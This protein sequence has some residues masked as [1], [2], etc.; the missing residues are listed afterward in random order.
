MFDFL[1]KKDDNAP[2]VGKE[3]DFEKERKKFAKKS[4]EEQEEA[5]VSGDEEEEE[6]EEEEV[7][8]KSTGK[9][10]G[11]KTS[12]SKSSNVSYENNYALEKIEARLEAL[13]E[14]IKGYNERFSQLSQQIGETRAMA[15]S[16]EKTIVK[17][18]AEA[19]KTI[20]VVKEVEPEKLRLDYQRLN[21]KISEVD[22]K[23]ETKKQFEE[24]LMNE[25]KDLRRKAGIFIGTEALLKLNE[26]VKK[27]LMELQRLSS[28][29]NMQ[30][31]KSEQIFIELQRGFAE[32]QKLT[33][34]AR[35]LDVN[36]AGL[37]K[38][39]EKLKL[40]Y[41]TIVRE[42]EIE[43]MKKKIDD[44]MSM[45]ESYLGQMEEVKKDNVR[46]SQMI[47]TAIEV[48]R[49]NKEDVEDIAMSLGND[50]I[51][52]VSDYENQLASVLKIIDTLAG[53]LNE[54]RAKVGISGEKKINV[55]KHDNKM[56]GKEKIN[57][58]NFELH[59]MISK[60]LVQK[61]PEV[62]V[63]IKKIQDRKDSD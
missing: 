8:E 10:S 31:D 29:V 39:I 2:D 53:R 28:R 35:N 60:P 40:D 6:T 58:K 37:K 32:N 12:A 50:K 46:L 20:D 7:E 15:I 19:E 51:K 26:E 17:A 62:P 48:S 30:S 41:T 16:N 3:D 22:E 1:K 49:R 52:R 34:V 59:P 45:F 27:D 42:K 44:R 24:T 36:Y 57:M 25:M 9:K 55:E 13:N 23:V 56:I 63:E 14:T 5:A 54:V 18:T 43:E 21:A 33:E 38:D 4:E 11:K 47:E 61:K